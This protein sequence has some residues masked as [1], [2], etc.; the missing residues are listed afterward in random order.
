MDM[1]LIKYKKHANHPTTHR[2]V[3]QRNLGL[4]WIINYARNSSGLVYFADDDNTYDYKLFKEFSQSIPIDKSVGVLPVGLVSKLKYEGPICKNGLIEKYH[5][6]YDPS[7]VFPI[8]MAGFAIRV[9]KIQE[10]Q[11]KFS[12]FFKPGHLETEYLSKILEMRVHTNW[13]EYRQGSV[14]NEWTDKNM[15]GLGKDCRQI[16]VW[17]TKTKQ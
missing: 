17:H 5:C 14:V 16:L 15:Q 13:E 8:D 1:K 9:S 11:T 10:R 6:Y 2:G 3:N 7:R 4:D 12:E